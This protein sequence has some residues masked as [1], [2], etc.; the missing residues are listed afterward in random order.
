[1]KADLH[2]QHILATRSGTR[3]TIALIAA[4]TALLALAFGVRAVLGMFLGPLNSATG[5]L[6]PPG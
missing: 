2:G 3:G 6:R 5:R 1:M 4:A